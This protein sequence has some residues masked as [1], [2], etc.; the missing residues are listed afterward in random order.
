MAL[1]LACV[2]GSWGCLMTSGPEQ[3]VRHKGWA[4]R[5]SIGWRLAILR[6]RRNGAGF[7]GRV[8][9]CFPQ[10]EERLGRLRVDRGQAV[11]VSGRVLAV[12]D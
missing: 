12:G 5:Q 3:R 4:R 2:R 9:P 10:R 11:R 1:Y 6:G 8:P 7:H